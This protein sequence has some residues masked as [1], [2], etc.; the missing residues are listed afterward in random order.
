M[1][2]G[3]WSTSLAIQ[4]IR[5]FSVLRMVPWCSFTV[6]L[7]TLVGRRHMQKTSNPLW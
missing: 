2:E 6:T 4:P 3:M 5:G 7:G 1:T